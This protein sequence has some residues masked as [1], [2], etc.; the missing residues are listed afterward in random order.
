M[1][2]FVDFKEEQ[3]LLDEAEQSRVKRPTLSAVP[4]GTAN[5]QPKAQPAELTW[6]EGE[7]RVGT[8]NE[9]EF[10]LKTPN[11][12]VTH[13]WQEEQAHHCFSDHCHWCWWCCLLQVSTPNRQ[14]Q[15]RGVECP[16]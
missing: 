10:I 16:D 9:G 4:T 13:G 3:R 5:T 1:N 15:L 2:G 8:D 11:P 12:A 7:T 14:I 6:E